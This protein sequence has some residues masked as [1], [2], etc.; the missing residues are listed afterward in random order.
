MPEVRPHSPANIQIHHGKPSL[1]MRAP[2]ARV[3]AQTPVSTGA[4]DRLPP[5]GPYG[6]VRG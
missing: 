1:R 2:E 6:P 5:A 4:R 3:R